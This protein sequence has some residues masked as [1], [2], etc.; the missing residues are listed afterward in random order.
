MPGKKIV[1][2]CDG[3][4][5]QFH[6][7]LANAAQEPGRYEHHMPTDVAAKVPQNS[8]NGF[9]RTSSWFSS[10][11]EGILA[12]PSNVTR[13]CRALKPTGADGRPQ[14]TYYQAGLGSANNWYSWYIGGYLGEGLSE[15]IR[16]A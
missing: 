7:T 10:D 2:A 8:D 3:Q 12:I 16:E 15:N 9:K 14:L 13:F 11:V 1:V 5:A 6:L 4:H